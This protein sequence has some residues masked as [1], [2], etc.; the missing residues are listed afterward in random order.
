M[1][2]QYHN[3]K[4]VVKMILEYA[5]LLSTAHHVLDN[6][7][8]NGNIYKKTHANHPSAV[9]VRSSKQNYE[10]LYS[11]LNAL[12]DEYTFRYGK[13]HKTTEK[14]QYLKHLPSNINDTSFTQPT[15]AMDVK[16]KQSQNAI[17]NYRNYYV[18]DE[19]KRAMLKYYTKRNQ[20]KWVDTY[21]VL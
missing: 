17:D 1:C 13:I 21:I 14:L 7:D 19:K 5:Q 11:L 2:A 8:F 20:P 16:F 4:H 3:D 15:E 12:L 6:N 10:W 18:N 9:W